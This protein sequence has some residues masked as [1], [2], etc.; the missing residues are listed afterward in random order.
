MP[1]EA[2]IISDSFNIL[3]EKAVK[4]SCKHERKGLKQGSPAQVAVFLVQ[5]G[6]RPLG[7]GL[8]IRPSVPCDVINCFLHVT[9]GPPRGSEYNSPFFG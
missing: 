6:A 7:G 4:G 8:S 3:D 2:P 1:Q 9:K 5:G